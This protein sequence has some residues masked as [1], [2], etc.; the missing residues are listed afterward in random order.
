MMVTLMTFETV[1]AI[2]QAINEL[3]ETHLDKQECTRITDIRGIQEAEGKITQ[4]N[5]LITSRLIDLTK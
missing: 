3:I 5:K 4:L 2:T 1:S